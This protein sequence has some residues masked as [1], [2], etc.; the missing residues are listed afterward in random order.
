MDRPVSPD[1]PKT[2]TFILPMQR[3][4]RVVLG[5]LEEFRFWSE[6]NAGVALSY[7]YLLRIGELLKCEVD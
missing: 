6:T 1:A 5:E 7:L 4:L 3:M 2:I